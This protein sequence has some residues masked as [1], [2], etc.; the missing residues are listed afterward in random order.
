MAAY[1]TTRD[2]DRREDLHVLVQQLRQIHPAPFTMTSQAAFDSATR[3]LEARLPQ[4]DDV[5]LLVELMRLTARLQDGH[6]GIWPMG[7]ECRDVVPVRV[8]SFE[9]GLFIQAAARSYAPYVGAKVLRIGTL[10]AEEALRRAQEIVSCDNEQSSL[11]RSPLLLTMPA[12]LHALGVCPQADRISYQVQLDSGKKQ[13]FTAEAI[14]TTEPWPTWY[15]GSEGVPGGDFVTAHDPAPA[16]TPLCRRDPQKN[17]WFEYLPN[18]HLLYFKFNQVQ[19]APDEPLPAFFARFFA[20]ADSH[21]VDKLVI[22]LRDN[23]GGNNTLEWPLIH[24]L[25]KRD[26]INRR[27]HLF[28]ITGRATFSAGMNCVTRLEVHTN[29]LF[30]GEPPGGRPNHYGDA[31]TITLP[32]SGLEVRIS[33]YLWQDS[34]PY[35]RRPWVAPDLPAPP[36]FAAYRANRDPALEAILAWSPEQTLGEQLKARIVREGA[37]AAE[38]FYREH[39]Q[40]HPDRWGKTTEA[41]INRAGYELLGQHQT[42]AAIAAFR[43]NADSYPRSPNVHDSLGEAYLQAGDREHAIACYRKALEVEPGFRNAQ[44]MLEQLARQ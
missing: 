30:V 18:E 20:F 5:Q 10:S 35:D 39:K 17:F 33:Q 25:I 6:T 24:G 3:A 44:R 13:D 7:E 14:K 26:A 16:P 9:E 36:T 27:G 1:A 4:L 40:R 32:H 19:H 12:I 37:A 41:E 31:T 11:D 2:E 28:T 38:V 34:T 21:A 8:Q 22:D 15:F 43:L 29:T 23:P 42:E